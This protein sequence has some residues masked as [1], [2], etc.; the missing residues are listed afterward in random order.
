YIRNLKE[1]MMAKEKI[2]SELNV[3]REIQMNMV[4]RDFPL[5]PSHPELNIH[6][7]IEP[8]KAV[9]GDFYDFVLSENKQKLAFSIGDVSGK[10]IPAAL[11]M[12]ITTTL[13]KA[14][15]AQFDDP[16]RVVS[17]VNRKLCRENKSGLFVT[18]FYGVLDL[19]TGILDYCVG[20]HNPPYLVSTEVATIPTTPGLPMGIDENAEYC[21]QRAQLQPN[22]TLFLFTDGV[23]ECR[24]RRGEFFEDAGIERLLAQYKT[25]ASEVMCEAV[26]SA[27]EEFSRGAAQSDDITMAAIKW[28]PELETV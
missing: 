12:A 23:T 2:E 8:A 10:G 13:I 25:A 6:S 15:S 11:F 26:V 7:Y 17:T 4:P 28:R 18:V 27:L 19:K 22:D 16:A 20:G 5:F 24:N 3:A 9:G 1:T 21:S 14:A